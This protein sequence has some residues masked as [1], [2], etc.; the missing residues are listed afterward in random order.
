M[1][2]SLVTKTSDDASL[3]S[4]DVKGSPY[5]LDPDQVERAA[6]ALQSHMLQH[7]QEKQQKAPKQNLADDE[8]EA[9][10]NDSII[11][12][13]IATKQHVKD[14]NRLKPNK[15]CVLNPPADIAAH[16]S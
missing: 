14:Q 7:A 8:D 3:A 16:C 11:Y 9:E 4:K 12:L 5:Q 6:K 15:M 1:A 2:K 10:S 13:N